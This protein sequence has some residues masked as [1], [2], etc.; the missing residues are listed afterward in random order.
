MSYAD[1]PR[2]RH[3]K[4]SERRKVGQRFRNYRLQV[5]INQSQLAALLDIKDRA[6]ISDI[7]RAATMPH[8]S[9]MAKF[10]G[11]ERRLLQ[12]KR[13]KRV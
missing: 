12:E 10:V 3:G 6:S 1:G 4:L 7:E 11:L 13:M 8:Q 5:G 2:K 9:T